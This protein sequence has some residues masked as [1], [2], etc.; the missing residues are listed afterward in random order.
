MAHGNRSPSVLTWSGSHSSGQQRRDQSVVDLQ[1]ARA[2]Y[3][4]FT[5]YW[6]Q[7]GR[8]EALGPPGEPKATKRYRTAKDLFDRCWL[9]LYELSQ[10]QGRRMPAD[11]LGEMTWDSV[12]R[13]FTDA[14][15][16]Y[17]GS[18]E[19]VQ[20]T[21]Y[22]SINRECLQSDTMVDELTGRI[23]KT[24]S[25][26]R[27]TRRATQNGTPY[28]RGFGQS[29]FF[30][31]VRLRDRSVSSGILVSLQTSCNALKEFLERSECSF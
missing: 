17:V 30:H 10:S 15:A 29:S 13:L 5:D 24:S 11:V 31:L 21:R 8:Q 22:R 27:K 28:S 23:C 18:R 25:R 2:H 6:E 16:S 4:D 12:L 9:E 3:G 14:R 7:G 1:E 19:Q 20:R 26:G